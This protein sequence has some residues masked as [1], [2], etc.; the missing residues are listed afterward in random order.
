M[1]GATRLDHHME[2]YFNSLGALAAE[3]HNPSG[4]AI[5]P[6]TV[7]PI[8][9]VA[10]V[11][12]EVCI[13]FVH[14]ANHQPDLLESHLPQIM[15]F[16][17]ATSS[18]SSPVEVR[19]E[20][21]E[22]WPAV[23]LNTQ[24]LANIQSPDSLRVILPTLL[25]NMVYA[26]EDFESMESGLIGDDSHVQDE[27]HDTAPIFHQD[28]S[29]RGAGGDG[30]NDD[31]DDSGDEEDRAVGGEAHGGRGNMS[32]WGNEW[33]VRKAAANALDNIASALNDEILPILLPLIE[34]GLTSTSDW[35]QQEASVLAVGAIAHGCGS[36]LGRHMDTLLPLLIQTTQSNQPLLR[37]IG[38]WALGR[39]ARWLA[40]QQ[41]ITALKS[42]TTAILQRC[43]DKNKRVQEAAIS[44]LAGLI[45]ESGHRIREDEDLI[46]KIIQV[47]KI[48]IRFYQYKNLL[49]LLDA[50]GTLVGAVGADVLSKIPSMGMEL[51]PTM[52]QRL[53]MVNN[54]NDKCLISLLE[55]L[56]P[57]LWSPELA[58]KLGQDG[59][60]M[61]VNRCGRI[62]QG[63]LQYIQ[64]PQHVD[65]QQQ[66]NAVDDDT[67]VDADIVAA[68]LDCLSAVAEGLHASQIL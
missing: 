53:R 61:V 56:T 29:T 16:M 24:W 13:G 37:S 63:Y 52:V 39:F 50:I 58:S 25:S 35:Q 64:L 34:K 15:Q 12:K 41:D 28:R 43:V 49:I 54:D 59:V 48:A 2:A 6:F 22:F 46:N 31:S 7:V 19:R 67:G 14:C 26:K 65:Q 20:A 4:N 45:E 36:G 8:I 55:A 5:Y 9:P 66:Q 40:A 27:P 32:T 60:T 3:S 17:L 42:A 38:C 21:L 68:A 30:D 18:Q 10:A 57:I 1:P 23:C 51:I 33:T 62:I 47:F 11:L 44:A